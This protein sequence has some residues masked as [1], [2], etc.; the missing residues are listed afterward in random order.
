M[1]QLLFFR[2]D[3]SFKYECK[4]TVRH[5]SNERAWVKKGS[6]ELGKEADEG[7]RGRLLGE[8]RRELPH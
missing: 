8:V 6:V 4:Q 5:Q 3:S 1:G 2:V 7:G